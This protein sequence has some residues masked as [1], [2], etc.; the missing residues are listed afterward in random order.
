[1][2]T[3]ETGTDQFT[4]KLARPAVQAFGMEFGGGE[5]TLTAAVL[6]KMKPLR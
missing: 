5:E 2:A 1:M 3:P 6:S 4:G